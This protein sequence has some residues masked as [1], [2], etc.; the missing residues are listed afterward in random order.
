TV[1]A[2]QLADHR[3]FTLSA[4]GGVFGLTG[5]V[6]VWSLGTPLSA[7]YSNNDKLT[8][9][10]FQNEDK[11]RMDQL[12]AD[13]AGGEGGRVGGLLNAYSKGNTTDGRS[14]ANERMAAINA[15]AS[16]SVNGKTANAAGLKSLLANPAETKGTQATVEAGAQLTA[17]DDITV[18]AT[19]KSVARFTTGGAGG[20]LLGVGG[21]VGVLNVAHNARTSVAGSLSAGG[22]LALTADLDET[23]RQTSVAFAGGVVGLGATVAIINDGSTAQASLADGGSVARAASL[24]VTA[25]ARQNFGQQTLGGAGGI[26]AAGASYA[27]LNVGRTGVTEVAASIGANTRVGQDGDVGHVAVDARSA[28]MADM[29]VKALAGGITGGQGNSAHIEVE[30]EVRAFIADGAL[31][32][33]RDSIAVLAAT[34]HRVEARVLALTIGG[35]TEGYD[36]VVTEL[37]PEVIASVGGTLNAA[38]GIAVQAAHNVDPATGLALRRDDGRLTGAFASADAPGASIGSYQHSSAWARATPRVQAL[39]NANAVLTAGGTVAVHADAVNIAQADG[40]GYT[41]TLAGVGFLDALAD[42]DGIRKALVGSGASI[43][44]GAL[45]VQAQSVDRALARSETTRVSGFSGNG[46][47]VSASASPLLQAEIGS[48]ARVRTSGNVAVRASGLNDADALAVALNVSLGGSFG[49]IDATATVKPRISALAAAGSDIVAQDIAIEAQHGAAAALADGSIASVDTAANTITTAQAHGLATGD[50]VQYTPGDGVTPLGGLVADKSYGVIVVDE[51][52][53]VLGNPFAAANVDAGSDT[54]RFASPHGLA[55]GDRMVYDFAGTGIGGLV[56]GQSYFV[57][58]IDDNTVKLGRTLAEVTQGLQAMAATAANPA[59]DVITLANHGFADGQ[60]VTYRGPY[61]AQFIGASVDADANRIYLPAP[62]NG[63]SLQT[64]EKVTYMSSGAALGGLGNNGTYYVNR[65]DDNAIQLSAKPIKGDG[66]DVFINLT[67]STAADGATHT[68]TRAGEKAIAGLTSGQTYYVKRIDANGF[69]LSATPGGATINI[70]V[71]GVGT[72]YIGVEGID[73][74]ATGASGQ[75]WLAVDLSGSLQGTGQ[76]LSGAGGLVAQDNDLGIDG[77]SRA[78][79]VAPTMALAVAGTG[80]NAVVDEAATVSAGIDRDARLKAAGDVTIASRNHGNA[81]ATAGAGAG[82]LLGGYG[83]SDARVFMTQSSTA[84]VGMGASIDAGGH[85]GVTA[86]NRVVA[87]GDAIAGALAAGAASGGADSLVQA[88]P[89]TTTSIASNARLTAKGDIDLDA[90][91]GAQGSSSADSYAYALLGSGGSTGAWWSVGAA[92]DD[93][94]G[95]AARQTQVDIAAGA[96]VASDRR[97]GLLAQVDSSDINASAEA[98]AMSLGYSDADAKARTFFNSDALVNVAGGAQLKG[99]Q[100]LDVT[101]AHVDANLHSHGYSVGGSAAAAPDAYAY[102]IQRQASRINVQDG[103]ALVS[104]A[105]DIEAIVDGSMPRTTGKAKG[106]SLNPWNQAEFHE[107]R[108]HGRERSISYDGDIVLLAAPVPRLVVDAAGNIAIAEGVTAH[109]EAGRIVVDGIGNVGNAGSV[110]FATNEQ[111]EEPE[112]NRGVIQGHLGTLISRHSYETIDLVNNSAKDLWVGDINPVDLTGHAKVTVATELNSLGFDIVNDFAP[113]AITIASAGGDVV[114]TGLIDNPIGCT[115]ITTGG[116]IVSGSAAQK[117]RSNTAALKAD[118]DIGTPASRLNVELVASSGR[119]TDLNAQAGGDL[120]LGLSLLE[121]GSANPGELTV[122]TL[123]AGGNVDLLLRPTLL[124]TQLSG[125]QGQYAVDVTET[126]SGGG[127][128]STAGYVNHYQP[129]GSGPAYVAPLA[130]FG[131][132]GSQVDTQANFTLLKAGG[133]IVVTAEPAATRINIRANTDV[134]GS[135]HVDVTTNGNMSLVEKAGDLRL[136]RVQTA[137]DRDVSLWADGSIVDALDDAAAD[138]VGGTML[139]SAGGGAIGALLNDVEIDSAG[140]VQLAAAKDVF[141]QET[142]GSLQIASAFVSQGDIRL[143]TADSA[144][145]GEN[146]EA[147][148]AASITAL[149]GAVTLQAGDAINLAGRLQAAG[150][151]TLRADFRNADQGKGGRVL[152]NGNVTAK[153]LLVE[154]DSD[155]DTLDVS[156]VDIATTAYGFAGN[157]RILTGGAADQLYGGE[158]SDD[159]WA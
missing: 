134:T 53:V 159:L 79:A 5:A 104:H 31:V 3:G 114:L 152:V 111:P 63:T 54:I 12:A 48:N 61:A 47:T 20:G 50:R 88:L 150:R 92:G 107:T 26:F 44:A 16:A 43:T 143:T 1:D 115:A 67:R 39:I 93:A 102:A 56:K 11:V 32:T 40:N 116:S 65:V 149:S 13:Q 52:T 83:H 132:G 154:G 38:G 101:A 14:N 17:G 77:V 96:L 153:D 6:S 124:Q 122:G 112:S 73:L 155:D 157:D 121:R 137:A 99:V 100:A 81:T 9:N 128:A 76:R 130:L 10:A 133:D 25:D 37:R 146:I 22:D 30:P 36:E 109:N 97:L 94:F 29:E 28:L 120:A 156:W 15:G 106:G 4:G 118:D 145:D 7:T 142:A 139:L 62:L 86:D 119:E 141:V 113:T 58:V 74:D 8:G 98:A 144:A 95:G 84:N 90:T 147:G 19:D 108:E 27:Q 131:T 151:L 126:L 60:A 18:R 110:R 66:S 103:A 68:L 49:K 57:R 91:M 75:Q 87:F 21:S 158:G 129:D 125:V 148:S 35:A 64:G 89:T 33:S 42:T 59:L 127:N 71:A 46:S 136:G 70:T 2:L 78:V 34:D 69:M 123:Q 41:A 140:Q 51:D 85:I 138:V 55:T 45:D 24:A 23:I 135:G 105:V 117:L 82:A 72:Q 80:A